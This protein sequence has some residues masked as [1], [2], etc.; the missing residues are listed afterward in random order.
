MNETAKHRSGERPTPLRESA[1]ALLAATG[2]MALVFDGEGN[3]LELHAPDERQFAPVLRNG[4][5][6]PV[7]EWLPEE[8]AARV[9][10]AIRSILAGRRVEP[11]RVKPW[12]PSD[13]HWHEFRFVPHTSG[14]ALC[15]VRD[16]TGEMELKDQVRQAHTRYRAMFDF[17]PDM[18][19]ITDY[20]SR[21][22]EQRHSGDWKLPG[23][24]DILE[25]RLREQQQRFLAIFEH[26]PLP[27]YLRAADGR[28]LLSNPA[29]RNLLGYGQE[30]DGKDLRDL[31]PARM[32]NKLEEQ[33]K[34]MQSRTKPH[35]FQEAEFLHRDGGIIPVEASANTIGNDS[36]ADTTVVV[37]LQDLRPRRLAEMNLRKSEARFRVFAQA[38]T[39]PLMITRL[40]DG[41]ILYI[42]KLIHPALKIDPQT[43]P[44]VGELAPNFYAQTSDRKSLLRELRQS[45]RVSMRE[46]ELVR[47]NGEHFWV[48]FSSALMEYEGEQAILSTYFDVTENKLLQEELAQS[49]KMTTLGQMSAGVAHEINTPLA[50]IMLTANQLRESKQGLLT[51]ETKKELLLIE[52]EVDRIS[53]IVKQLLEFSRAGPADDVSVID[54][55]LVA[56][57]ALSMSSA[58]LKQQRIKVRSCFPERPL[59]V[60]GNAGRLEQV[61]INL[62]TNSRHV[63]EKT[64]RKKKFKFGSA[65]SGTA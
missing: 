33:F 18:T 7:Y 13:E 34:R 30:L 38:I 25:Q 64:P 32:L 43:R 26:S 50:T 35:Y 14:T 10:E 37:I 54:L 21:F 52:N 56:Q 46:L 3:C 60:K 17:M 39:V 40:N 16:V 8:E 48:L 49:Q 9:M 1:D 24:K 58:Q 22:L 4:A 55:A 2:D 27:I 6:T 44:L 12:S 20:E 28:I 65:Q 62:I 53:G 57:K 23:G 51:G 19:A 31:V 11:F 15:V 59:P 63:L 5:R 36:S 61:V 29:M 47:P 45:G 41:K 42:N